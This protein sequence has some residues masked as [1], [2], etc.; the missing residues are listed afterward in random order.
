MPTACL[1]S[2]ATNISYPLVGT[3]IVAGYSPAQVEAML[4]SRLMNGGYLRDPQ[5]SVRVAEYQ[6]QKV[7]VLGHV[8]QPGQHT[9]QTVSRILDVLAAAAAS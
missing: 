1:H 3:L 6:S 7:S 4:S 8:S 9:R 5:V 2:P